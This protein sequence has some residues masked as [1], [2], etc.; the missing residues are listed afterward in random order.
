MS[1]K[2]I[3]ADPKGV[4]YCTGNKVKLV[5]SG[6]ELPLADVEK[7]IPKS[8]LKCLFLDKRIKYFESNEAEVAAKRAKERASQAIISANKALDKAAHK[9]LEAKKAEAKAA[10]IAEDAKKKAK[11]A[12]DDID[13][14]TEENEEEAIIVAEK[15][16]KAEED[17]A[18]LAKIAEEKARKAES[19][20]IAKL[21]QTHSDKKAPTLDNK[22]GG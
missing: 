9:E 19:E 17:A 13:N 3:V 4:K 15:A 11:Q 1:K 12:M 22:S 14:E 5:L 7:Y 6:K 10:R 2:I 18:R 8:T 21:N 16:K 20:A